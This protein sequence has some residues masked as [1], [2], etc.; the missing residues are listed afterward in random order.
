MAI[1]VGDTAEAEFVVAQSDTAEALAIAPI[2]AFPAVFATSRMVALM[3]LAAARLMK[4]LLQAARH[5]RAVVSTDR[6]L[7]GAAQRRAPAA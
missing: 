2:D 7:A 5:T 4:R 6:L 3:E 1:E